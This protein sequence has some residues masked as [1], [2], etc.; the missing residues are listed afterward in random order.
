MA[1]AIAQEVDRSTSGQEVDRST[2]DLVGDSPAFRKVL[3]QISALA[4]AP[5]AVLL[6]GE[7]GTGKERIARAIHAGGFRSSAPFVTVHCGSQGSLL[8]SDGEPGAPGDETLRLTDLRSRAAAGTLFLDRVEML[9]P[10]AQLSLLRVLEDR[11]AN[12]PRE[13]PTSRVRFIAGTSVPL[14]PLVKSDRFRADLFYRLAVFAITIP[15][16]RD[17]REDVLPLAEHFLAQHGTEGA[18]P[19]RLSAAAVQALMTYDW[20]GNVRELES[21]IVRAT[22]RTKT[23]TIEASDLGLPV[24]SGLDPAP[25][26]KAQKRR[27]LD[28]F[29]RHYLTRL[30]AEHGGNV[31]HAAVTAGKERRD[32]GKLL[33]RHGIDPRQFIPAR[34]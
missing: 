2:G 20:P 13:N 14:E 29:E 10:A 3:T 26:Y 6:C 15:P 1:E 7:S 19:Q 12:E 34:H 22:H 28:A 17:R 25:T 8:E 5:E 21:A 9:S 11:V 31:T 18:P 33:K 23:G 30:M 27:I 16:L 32:L 4:D 24:T